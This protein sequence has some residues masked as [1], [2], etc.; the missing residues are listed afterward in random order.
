MEA[1]S[2]DHARARENNAATQTGDL[3]TLVRDEGLRPPN[4][5]ETDYRVVFDP[6][7]QR[8]RHDPGKAKMSVL[9]H[10]WR[11]SCNLE[12]SWLT[13]YSDYEDCYKTS[14]LEHDKLLKIIND[15]SQKTKQPTLN[16]SATHDWTGVEE[17]VQAAC[18]GMSKCFAEDSAVP[19]LR[20]KLQKGFRTVCQHAGM[21]Q[22]FVSLIPS[23]IFGLSSLLCGALKLIFSAMQQSETCRTEV[24]KALAE[25][26]VIICDHSIPPN[27]LNDDEQLHRRASELYA[28]IFRFLGIIFIWQSKASLGQ[29]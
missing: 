12:M 26:P 2:S 5:A 9:C 24:Y 8:W 18:D 23:D 19:G 29:Y 11:D 15:Y 7:S 17:S 21:G 13:S 27:G 14:R 1:L 20:G 28:S 10:I 16:L 25:L 22:S 4:I 3:H 6:R